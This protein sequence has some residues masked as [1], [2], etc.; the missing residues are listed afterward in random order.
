MNIS[1]PSDLQDRIDIIN[2]TDFLYNN[3]ALCL[4]ACAGSGKTTTIIQKITYMIKNLNLDPKHFFITTFTRNATEELKK[5]LSNNLT[6]EIVN[7]MTIGTFHSISLKFL[8]KYNINTDITKLQI[9]V[10]SFLYKYYDLINSPSNSYNESHKYIFID[11]YQDINE[12]QHLII[13]QLYNLNQSSNSSLLMVVG[14]DQQNIYSFRKTS[15]KYILN[16]TT[17]FINSSYHYLTSNFRSNKYIVDVANSIIYHNEEKIDKLMIP[18]SDHVMIKPKVYFFSTEKIEYD[19]VMKRIHT[20]M[21]FNVPL[22]QIAILSRTNKKLYKIENYLASINIASINLDTIDDNLRLRNN[23]NDEIENIT[24][25]KIILST[26]H[27]SKGL[28]YE[29]VILIG[30]VDGAFPI[31]F[32][33]IEEERRLFYVAVTRAKKCLWM[34][35]L[36]YDKYQPSRF[37]TELI[38]HNIDLLDVKIKNKMPELTY[39]TNKI[40]FVRLGVKNISR[41]LDM[42]HINQLNFLNILPDYNNINIEIS[43]INEPYN[44]NIELIKNNIITG[45][46][47]IL[48]QFI[49]TYITRTI[50][51]IH[52]KNDPNEEIYL[53]NYMKYDNIL[54][55]HHESLRKSLIK[56]LYDDQKKDLIIMKEMFNRLGCD[57]LNNLHTEGTFSEKYLKNLLNLTYIIKDELSSG[58]IIAI[59]NDN[60][61]NKIFRT[62]LI[63]S[64]NKFKDKTLES[65]DIMFEIFIVSLIYEIDRG[66]YAIQYIT[67]YKHSYTNIEL[68]WFKSIDNFINQLYQE[69]NGFIYTQYYLRDQYS[70]ISGYA[71]IITKNEIIDIKCTENPIPQFEHFIQ[72]LL[73]LSLYNSQHG[74]KINR[75]SIY[76]PLLGK[77]YSWDLT[78]WSKYNEFLS[79]IYQ[80]MLQD[81]EDSNK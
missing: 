17:N 11:E 56:Y 70:G 55:K 33:D 6:L 80:L 66:R 61:L 5:R 35:S 62:K 14:D 24:K 54:L 76:N 44:H 52:A 29:Y 3:I 48:G 40:N 31:I 34:T 12:I 46:D 37:I 79:N 47:H 1:T 23:T 4:I 65:H 67:D 60:N 68:N 81:A 30:C 42:Q 32:G 71:D 18:Q 22:N 27:G 9:P 41:S 36:W 49:D 7:Q 78:T 69:N 15:I 13:K 50:L 63:E 43:N 75:I 51:Q 16:F 74:D 25:N 38:N 64:Y 77:K 21:S 73:Y 58:S 59:N 10:E 45:I 28:E 26:V 20:L 39:N 57:L 53:F 8:N 72:L 2:N 19:F